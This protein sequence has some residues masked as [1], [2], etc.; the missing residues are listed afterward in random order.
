MSTQPNKPD[1]K[2]LPVNIRMLIA[3]ALTGLVIFGTPYFYKTVGIKLPEKSEQQQNAEKNAE[4]KPQMPTQPA[5]SPV[6]QTV[7]PVTPAKSAPAA[8]G[9]PQK[10][11]AAAEP[12]STQAVSA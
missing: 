3:F 7:P 1:P 5:T 4:K 10:K 2:D 6:A 9:R 11:G 12:A 8:A